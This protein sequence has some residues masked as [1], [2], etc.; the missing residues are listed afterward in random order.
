MKLGQQLITKLLTEDFKPET[1][2]KHLKGI[3][4]TERDKAIIAR[5]YYH[6]KIKGMR[7]DFALSTLSVEFYLG[8]TTLAQII[9][10]GRDLLEKLKEEKTGSRELSAKFPHYNWN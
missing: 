9:M 6:Y 3:Y 7:Y 8:E 4:T 1:R 2:P 5:L 10:R